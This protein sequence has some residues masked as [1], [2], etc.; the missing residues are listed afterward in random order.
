MSRFYFQIY[1]TDEQVAYT[2]EIVEYSL[3]HHT[4][5]DI[6]ENDRDGTLQTRELRFIGSLGEV[7]F[8]D[9]YQ[10]NRPT[11]SFGATDGQDNGQDFILPINNQNYSFDIKS[12]SRKNN[13][14]KKFY[15]LNIP[16]YQ[17]VK[18]NNIT[19]YYFCISI[20]KNNNQYIASFVGCAKKSEI[21]SGKVGELYLKGTTRMK[22]NGETFIFPRNTYEV[23]FE[24]FSNPFI[25][26]RIENLLGFQKFQLR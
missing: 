13:Q 2:N 15:V 7:V 14:F 20:H 6:F 21:I 24:E 3:Q 25:T 22:A 17:I 12:M 26:E 23:K 19:D 8:A 11:R 5:P 16:E 1:V 4:I 18:P 10:L 9:A